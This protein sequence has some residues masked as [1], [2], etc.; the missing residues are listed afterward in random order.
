M[1]IRI[2]KLPAVLLVSLLLSLSVSLHAQ[3]WKED[4]KINVL[5]GLTQP[6]LVKGFNIEGNY[7]HNRLIF[8]Y[9]HGVSL[10][11]SG[12]SVTT[13][14]KR[15]N[16]AVHMPWTTGFGIGYRVKEWINVRIEPK[17]HKFE[18]YYDGEVQNSTNIITS[19]NTMSL[20]IGLYGHFQPFKNKSSFIKGIMIAPSVRYWPTVYSSLDGDQYTYFNKYTNSNEEI[21]VLDPGIGFTPFVFNISIGYSFDVKRK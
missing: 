13:D 21:E 10:D 1:T 12:N 4:K 11:F 7:I 19:Y 8:D 17:W 20:G 18:F 14:L 2:H 9:S 3:D 16:V 15:Q 6:L 5:F